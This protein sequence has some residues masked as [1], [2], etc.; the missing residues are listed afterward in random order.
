VFTQSSIQGE[1]LISCITIFKA[2]HKDSTT[3]IFYATLPN[4]IF[5]QTAKEFGEKELA[6]AKSRTPTLTN[7]FNYVT[8][9]SIRFFS[10]AIRKEISF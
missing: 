3:S 6:T 4:I 2:E 1:G 7:Y 8:F 10:K 5:G 9:Q